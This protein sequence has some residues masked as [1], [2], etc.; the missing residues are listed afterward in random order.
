MDVNMIEAEEEAEVEI[1]TDNWMKPIIDYLKNSRLLLE[2]KNE[3]RKLRL[4]ATRYTLVDKTLIR[5]S[6]SGPLLRCVT[7]E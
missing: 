4:K 7:K 6:F 3:A 1:T 2:D 5:K